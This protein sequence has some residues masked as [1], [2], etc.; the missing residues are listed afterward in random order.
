MLFTHHSS[1]RY[2]MRLVCESRPL[3]KFI[4]ARVCG[5]LASSAVIVPDREDK[6]EGVY[7]V[8]FSMYLPHAI[9]LRASLTPG[10]LALDDRVFRLFQHT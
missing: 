4:E 1:R 6:G 5:E 3:E 2:H 7:I 9:A 8:R 10:T